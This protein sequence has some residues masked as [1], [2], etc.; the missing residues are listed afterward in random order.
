M[1]EYKGKFLS[2]SKKITGTGR[3]TKKVRDKLRYYY[4]KAIPSNVVDLFGMMIQC[5]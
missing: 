3:L 1:V 2:N 4:G 5:K